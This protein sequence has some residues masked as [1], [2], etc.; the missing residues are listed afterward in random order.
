MWPTRAPLP[1]FAH[2]GPAS[3]ARSGEAALRCCGAATRQ[4]FPGKPASVSRRQSF[5]LSG[6]PFDTGRR[7]ALRRTRAD[8][9]APAARSAGALWHGPSPSLESS[10]PR[11][12]DHA[13]VRLLGARRDGLR[14]IKGE[15][16]TVSPNDDGTAAVA[17]D[18]AR[19]NESRRAKGRTVAKAPADAGLA[20]ALIA[21]RLTHDEAAIAQMRQ[22][23]AAT[24]LAHRAG[25]RAT[26]QGIR[27]AEIAAAMVGGDLRPRG[28][29]RRTSP[30]SRCTAKCCTTKS[31]RQRGFGAGDL[32]LAD[33]GAETPEGWAGGRD[34][35]V[36]GERAILDRRSAQLYEVGPAGAA[37]GDCHGAARGALP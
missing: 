18:A 28:C 12:R 11:T 36:A 10:A 23:A 20:E 1:F 27:E 21:L 25:M 2:A 5:S 3:R 8:P 9:Y 37:G 4:E 6:G 22:A 30:S 17:L 32:V 24:A 16:A 26:R 7:T 19:A 34:P 14:T 15:V 13:C 33:V 35:G 29:A 31:I